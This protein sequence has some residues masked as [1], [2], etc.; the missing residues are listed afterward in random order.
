MFRYSKGSCIR[1]LFSLRPWPYLPVRGSKYQS[2]AENFPSS[3]PSVGETPKSHG[4]LVQMSFPICKGVIF[5]RFSP[6][7]DSVENLRAVPILGWIKHRKFW[8]TKKFNNLQ[9]FQRVK[10]NLRPS[11][12]VRSMREAKHEATGIRTL[13]ES[14]SKRL[15]KWMV[16][17]WNFLLGPG[18]FS[19]G[20]C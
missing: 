20:S 6:A 9:S 13:P 7:V 11:P 8:W 5:F 3:Q 17:R 4:G 15:W 18:L 2:E 14:N 16:G 12:F 10:N 19:G 1:F